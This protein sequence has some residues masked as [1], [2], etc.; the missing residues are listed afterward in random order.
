[1]SDMIIP[2]Y[3][4]HYTSVDVLALILQ[5]RTIRLNPL[6]KLDDKQE[7]RTADVINL[8]KFIFVSSWTSD[9]DESIPMWKMYTEPTAGVRI[10]LKA[11]PF[12]Q[13]TTPLKDIAK[14][15]GNRIVN[16]TVGNVNV[17]SFLNLSILIDKGYFSAQAW[18]GDILRKVIYTDDSDLLEPKVLNSTNDNFQIEIGKMGIYKDSH[19]SFQ[20]EWRYLMSFFPLKISNI[21]TAED[22]FKTMMMKLAQGIEEPP[23][24]Y[25]DLDIDPEMFKQME[26]TFSP[27]ISTANRTIVDALIQKYNPSANLRESVLIGNL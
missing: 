18:S 25:Y 6:S 4:Y 27:Q 24:D 20:N 21:N 26:I 12:L 9:E 3:L 5:N 19:W 16:E 8:G 17:P 23:F 13:H 7:Q 11:N 2:E 1:M 22:N 14:V 15:F 10:R